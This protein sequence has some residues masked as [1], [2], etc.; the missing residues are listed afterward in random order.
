MQ[1]RLSNCRRLVL[2]HYDDETEEI[3]FRHFA[4]RAAPVGVQ[5]S[6]KKVVKE[7]KRVPDLNRF[8]DI[9]DYVLDG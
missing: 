2:F 8:S 1:I 4:I 9:S 7:Q 5:R 6:V 3:S